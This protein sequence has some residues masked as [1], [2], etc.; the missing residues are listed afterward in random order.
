MQKVGYVRDPEL[1]KNYPREWPAWA[2]ITLKDGHTVSAHVRFPKGDPENPLSWEELVE[3]YC[4][5]AST[6]W[7]KKKVNAVQGAVRCLEEA[8][9]LCDLM[10]LLD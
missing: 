1:E 4:A 9:N 5:L 7:D 2:R 10:R 3:K 8:K 6:V